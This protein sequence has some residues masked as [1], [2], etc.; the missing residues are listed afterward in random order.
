MVDLTL[1]DD[2]REGGMLYGV[3]RCSLFGQIVGSQISYDFML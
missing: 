1:S 2:E 3:S